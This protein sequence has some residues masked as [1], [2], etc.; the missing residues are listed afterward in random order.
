MTARKR[1]KGRARGQ[2][3]RDRVHA[4]RRAELRGIVRNLPKGKPSSWSEA[5][6]QRVRRAHKRIHGRLST[7]E[8]GRQLKGSQNLRTGKSGWKT[9]GVREAAGPLGVRVKLST[10]R[11]RE[12][13]NALT[14]GKLP[15]DAQVAWVPREHPEASRAR[16]DRKAATWVVETEVAKGQ[17]VK[18]YTIPLSPADVQAILANPEAWGGELVERF[19]A[20]GGEQHWRLHGQG[21]AWGQVGDPSKTGFGLAP[22][23]D[24]AGFVTALQE[25][26]AK[27]YPTA[28]FAMVTVTVFDGDEDEDESVLESLEEETDMQAEAS[29]WDPSDP[30]SDPDG[31]EP[32]F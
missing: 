23:H 21:G 7:D 20:I 31:G 4:A 26:A 13:A 19:A 3:E 27:R 15:R 9:V 6:K 14:R 11:Q 8:K 30:W 18:T 25:G 17:R 5:D 16:W 10:K 24:G 28:A 1:S 22:S 2:A 12:A 32:I 29:S